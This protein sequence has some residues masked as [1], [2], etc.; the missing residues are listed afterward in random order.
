MG[1]NKACK[2]CGEI[3]AKGFPRVLA[4]S[5]AHYTAS[6][7]LYDEEIK[8]NI[9]LINF[10]TSNEIFGE[11]NYDYTLRCK[12][13]GQRFGCKKEEII[14]SKWIDHVKSHYVDRD[15]IKKMDSQRNDPP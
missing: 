2:I 15:L 8:K 11:D 6:E 13:C 4:H 12:V 10:E 9:I 14:F 5:A 7:L 1:K 3:I